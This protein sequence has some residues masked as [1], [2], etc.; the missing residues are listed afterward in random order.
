MI[1]ASTNEL[2]ETRERGQEQCFTL[3]GT[4]SVAEGY[5]IRSPNSVSHPTGDSS[6]QDGKQLEKGMC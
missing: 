4:I 1:E 2:A 3:A 6:A 5:E